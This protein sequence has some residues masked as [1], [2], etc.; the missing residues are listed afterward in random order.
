[1]AELSLDDDE[2]HAFMGHRDR[3]PVTLAASCGAPFS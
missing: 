2:W 1:V 3:A